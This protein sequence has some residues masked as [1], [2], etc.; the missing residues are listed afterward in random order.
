VQKLC[1]DGPVT[2]EA[3]MGVAATHHFAARQSLPGGSSSEE[4]GSGAAR[5]RRAHPEPSPDGSPTRLGSLL[6]GTAILD[7]A[8]LQSPVEHRSRVALLTADAS[9]LTN[10]TL[11]GTRDTTPHPIS[12]SIR[13]AAWTDDF[14]NLFSAVAWR[15]P[16]LI[17]G[18]TAP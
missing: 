13:G 14:A 7:H 8:R 3:S 10:P 5:L 1:Y 6:F 4:V 12:R 9:A 18:R 16:A 15:P 2:A 11:M 17:S